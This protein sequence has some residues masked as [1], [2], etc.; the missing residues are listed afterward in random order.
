MMDLI[1]KA[2][3]THELSRDELIALLN[4]GQYC[5]ELFAAADNVRQNTSAMKSIFAA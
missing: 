2:E 4:D 3:E 1:K 5:E